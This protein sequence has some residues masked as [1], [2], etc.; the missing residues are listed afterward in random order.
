M[1]ESQTEIPWQALRYVIG[2]ITYGGRVT[3]D[4]DRRTL[5][6]VLGKYIVEDVLQDGFKLSESGIYQ[7]Y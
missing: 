7:S 2:D 4:W 3:D 6:T 5:K 1:L